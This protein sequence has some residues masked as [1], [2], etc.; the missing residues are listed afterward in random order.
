LVHS[1]KNCSHF[2]S[3]QICHNSSIDVYKFKKLNAIKKELPEDSSFVNILNA[4]RIYSL[5]IN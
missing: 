3:I 1:I 4:I 2:S 5:M